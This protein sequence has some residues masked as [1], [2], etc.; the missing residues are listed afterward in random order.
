MWTM[1]L[2]SL[3]GAVAG[4]LLAFAAT[5]HRLATLRTRVQ[6]RDRE[7][8]QARQA[9]RETREQLERELAASR[10][11]LAAVDVER[12]AL[13]RERERLSVELEAERRAIPDKLA[14]LDTAEKRMREAFDAAC[15]QALQTNN[16]TF[17]D[18]ANARFSE[19]Q[20]VAS[21]ELDG[22]HKS[23]EVLLSPVR[24]GLDRVGETL[25]KLDIDRAETQGA[26]RAQL[27]AVAQHGERLAGETQLLAR[28]LR[29][30]HVRGQW[31]EMQLRRVAE[32]A[33]MLEHCDFVEQHTVETDNGN[34]RPDLIVHLPG[35]KLVVVDSKAPLAAFLDAQAAEDAATRD[36]L[37]DRHARHVRDHITRLADKS[38]G[39]RFAEAPDFVVMFLPG[40]AFFSEACR[41]DPSLIDYAVGVGVMPASPITLITLLKAIAFGWQ[42][43]RLAENA[44]QLR[45]LGVE[46]YDRVRVLAEHLGGLR[47]GLSAAVIAYNRTVGSLEE[48]FLPT[49]RKFKHLGIGADAETPTLRSIDRAPRLPSAPELLT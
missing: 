29:T 14:V 27:E 4:A 20:Q 12:N 5:A 19:L 34:L 46:L 40:E 41:R 9:A 35:R 44:E 49:A 37:L 42:Q 45:D 6:E 21:R 3:G 11:T 15:Q 38:Y 31:G 24:D 39:K 25:R 32:L 33:G 43:E 26:I 22:K 48:R 36:S 28:A 16:R 13:A 1:M 17:L 7:I 47:K 23:I 8:G 18:L 30:P 10:Q 2:V